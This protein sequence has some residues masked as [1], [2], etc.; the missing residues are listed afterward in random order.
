MSS[1]RICAASNRSGCSTSASRTCPIVA[2]S[3]YAFAN[4]ERAPDFLRMTI[5]LGAACCLRKPFTPDALLTR[6]I[7][8]S[9]R[10]KLP[11]A[12]R[13]SEISN[14]QCLRSVSSLE[15][16]SLSS[17]SSALPR[18][19]WTSSRDPIPP[20]STMRSRVLKKISDMR[21][22]LRR[23]ESAA[24]GLR[25]HRRS[26][27]RQGIPRRQRCDPA[28]PRRPDRGRQGQSRRKAAD[29]RDQGAGGAPDCA[30][31]RTDQAAESRETAP[32]VAALVGQEDR[33]ATAAIAG[34]LE[35]AVA[36]ERRLL[37]AQTRR[38]R[39]QRTHPAGD[40][41]RRR[42]ADPDPRHRAD[43]VEPAARAGNCRIRSPPPRP[44][45]RRWRPR[46]PSAPSIWLPRMTSSGFRPPCCRAPSTAW[47]RRCS[48]STPRE[49]SCSP[50]RP[51]R[52]CCATGR[53]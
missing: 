9:P 35:K 4:T 50:I 1:C 29:R 53:A 30:Q 10:R 3:G 46:S 18:S 6:S 24:R 32:A 41:S 33:A 34:N 25:A 17:S 20:P 48:S 52:R 12:S 7:N 14:W 5:E 51:P 8:A 23:A 2:M 36:E 11:R 27:I 47:R 13:N 39:N 26:G 22:L 16:A 37:F 19:V 28:G 21:P 49:R 45:T 44:P 40:R 15:L 31:W 42:R 38:I 43:A